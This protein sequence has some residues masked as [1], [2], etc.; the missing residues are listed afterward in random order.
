MTEEIY[1]KSYLQQFA[2]GIW[3]VFSCSEE[4]EAAW[5]L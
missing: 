3:L 2:T 5:L 1:F 4:E